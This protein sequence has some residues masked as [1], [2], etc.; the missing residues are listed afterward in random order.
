MRLSKRL[1]KVLDELNESGKLTSAD[2]EKLA[3]ATAPGAGGRP[4]RTDVKQVIDEFSRAMAFGYSRAGGKSYDDAVNA[5][6]SQTHI[7]ERRIKSAIAWFSDIAGQ[8]QQD[9]VKCCKDDLEV[10]QRIQTSGLNALHPHEVF[11]MEVLGA[12]LGALEAIPV[13]RRASLFLN[14]SECLTEVY[15][16]LWDKAI[17]ETA[18]ALKAWAQET[19]ATALPDMVALANLVEVIA[20]PIAIS[21]VSKLGGAQTQ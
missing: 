4:A 17:D 7:S 21:E 16:R 6:M 3:R 5:A 12:W 14:H 10:A 11:S 19:G 2:Q 8:P 18:V 13:E 9:W 1:Q 20:V 15:S